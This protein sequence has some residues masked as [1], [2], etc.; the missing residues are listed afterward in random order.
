MQI[1]VSNLVRER[2]AD[3]EMV[4]TERPTQKDVGYREE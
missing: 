3:G 2:N 1:A 4:H